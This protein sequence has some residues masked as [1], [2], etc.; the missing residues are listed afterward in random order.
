MEIFLKSTALPNYICVLKDGSFCREMQI[1]NL[2]D[3]T[4]EITETKRR[5]P[6]NHWHR[7]LNDTNNYEK[8]NKAEFM[9]AYK[10]AKNTIKT[11]AD[12]LI[13]K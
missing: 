5:F 3:G 8:S 1:A 6:I 9:E 4:V 10:S 2:T 7:M 13:L 12:Q 11:F